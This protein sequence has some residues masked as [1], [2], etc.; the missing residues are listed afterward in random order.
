MLSLYLFRK[1]IFGLISQKNENGKLKNMLGAKKKIRY[2]QKLARY[3]KDFRYQNK[4]LSKEVA[5]ILGYSAPKY[6]SMESD[7]VPYDRFINAIE[8]LLKFASLRK[9]SLAEFICYIDGNAKIAVHNGKLKKWESKVLIML[10]RMSA[11]SRNQL[12][13]ILDNDI[14][15]LEEVIDLVHSLS[16]MKG[17]DIKKLKRGLNLLGILKDH[18]L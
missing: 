2:Q 8:F 14:D 12:L 13:S 18:Q 15:D 4:L 16:Y 9:F 11:S 10:D 3:L 17:G 5:N 7:L 6:T 1:L